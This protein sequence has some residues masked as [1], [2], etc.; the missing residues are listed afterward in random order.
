MPAIGQVEQASGTEAKFAALCRIRDA[1]AAKDK[2]GF[3]SHLAADIEYHYHVGSKPLLGRDRVDRFIT[4]YWADN[5]AG[6]WIIDRHAET[7]THLFTEGR[8]EYVNADGA[9]V[10]HPYMGIME[11]DSAGLIVKW[12]DYFQMADPNA[13]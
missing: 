3:L 11:F 8:E 5:S 7:Q 4:K 2:D 10:V 12:R 13:A 6:T 9:T 1:I